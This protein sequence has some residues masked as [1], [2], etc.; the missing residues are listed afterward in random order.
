[1]SGII[2]NF[3]NEY[4][5]LSNFFYTKIKYKGIIFITSEHFYQTCK[6]FVPHEQQLIINSKTPGDAKKNSRLVTLRD[7]WDDIKNNIMWITLQ[8]K[9]SQN[10]ILLN[11]LKATGDAMLVEGTTGWHDNY[12]GSCECKKCINIEGQNHLGKMLMQLRDRGLDSKY[13]QLENNI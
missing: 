6:T 8:L 7:N 10:I 12:W 3:R 11:K 9:F 2:N 1:M 5:F 13:Q 4:Y